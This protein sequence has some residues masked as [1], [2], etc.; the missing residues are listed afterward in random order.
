M[1]RNQESNKK[2]KDLIMRIQDQKDVSN[3]VT[4]SIEKDS[5][6]QQASTNA[7]F[8][9]LKLV[10]ILW[11]RTSGWSFR[12]AFIYCCRLLQEEVYKD[13]LSSTAVD[14]FRTKSTAVDESLSKTSTRCSVPENTN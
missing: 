1:I 14:F 8:A 2:T 11:N 13:K 12:Q 5:G 9:I 10:G 3:V 7:R 6:V 4:P